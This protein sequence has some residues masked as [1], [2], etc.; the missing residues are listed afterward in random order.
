[1]DWILICL[2]LA[3]ALGGL[4]ILITGFVIAHSMYSPRC[5]SMEESR[6]KE[7]ERTPDLIAAYDSWKKDE[8]WIDSP[9]GYRLKTYHVGPETVPPDGTRRFCIVAHGYTHTH[10]GGVKYAWMMRKFGF[11]V[12]LYDERHHGLSGGKTCS[13]GYYES[14]DLL[15][16][17]DDTFRRHGDDI[18][19]GVY[20]ESMGATA[21]LLAQADDPR[22]RFT[23]ADC[24]FSDL[25]T[26]VP[27]LIK[28]LHHLPRV[29]FVQAADFFFRLA[30]KVSLRAIRPLEAVAWAKSPILFIHGESDRFIPPE[31]SRI[32]H[33]ACP[34][35][36]EIWLAPNGARHAE[37]FRKNRDEYPRVLER[38]MREKVFPGTL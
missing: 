23:V 18:F 29:P 13:L 10:L 38:F 17:I 35:P 16:V 6:A 31:H 33:Q 8:Y 20:G 25:S 15:A 21:A 32:L 12:V 3:V 4:G 28:D 11:D 34:A 26:L 36:K 2:S 22:I 19:L 1:M 7:M 27:W 9:F 30:N 37:S 5:L 14:M 24:P